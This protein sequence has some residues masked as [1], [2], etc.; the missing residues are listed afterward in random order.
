MRKGFGA[1]LIATSGALTRANGSF[2]TNL[3]TKR[4][5]S[6]FDKYK[7]VI[8]KEDDLFQNRKSSWMENISEFFFGVSE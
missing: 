1:F 7:N 2:T 8:H 4:G 3:K 6:G 5:T